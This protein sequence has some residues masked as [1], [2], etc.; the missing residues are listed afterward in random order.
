MISYSRV[1]PSPPR[2]EQDWT[3]E[4]GANQAYLVTISEVLKY[5]QKTL[6]VG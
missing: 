4:S 6:I 1:R 2:K 5:R 3:G